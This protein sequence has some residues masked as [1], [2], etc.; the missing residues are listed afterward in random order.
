MKKNKLAKESSLYL[1]Q[2]ADNPVE[3]Y[4]W[5][6]EAFAK[7]VQE[8]KPVLLSIGY[9]ACHWCHVMANESFSD[10]E[11]AQLM[12]EL[13]VNIKVDKQER[14]DLDKIYLIAHQF[15]TGRGGGWPLTIFINPVDRMP[16]FAGTYFPKDPHHG[17]V[18]FKEVLRKIAAFYHNNQ[19]AIVKQNVQ[20]TSAFEQ[21]EIIHAS[22]MT[23]DVNLLSEAMQQFTHEYDAIYGGFGEAPK[24]PRPANLEFLLSYSARKNDKQ[25]PDVSLAIVNTSLTKMAQ[26]GLY[27]HL[28]GGF[29]RYCVDEQWHIPHFEKMLYDNG[30]LLMV[31]AMAD[32]IEPQPIFQHIL[33]QTGEWVLR[34]M[35][36]P[37]GGFYSTLDADSEHEEGKF[38]L[39]N[40]AEVQSLLTAE[41]YTL[42]AAYFGLEKPANFEGVWH[43]FE[44]KSLDEMAAALNSDSQK[45]DAL[46]LSACKKLFQAREQRIHPARDENILTSWNALMIKGLAL[47][48]FALNNVD[49]IQSAQRAID[50]VRTHRWKNK[51][52]N[53]GARGNNNAYLDDYAFLLDA[54]IT[55]LTIEWRSEDL[56]FAVEIADS[57]LSHFYDEANGGFYFTSHENESLISRLKP[58]QDEAIPA[59]NGIAAFALARLGNLL[60]EMRYK[61]ASENTLKMAALAIASYPAAYPSLLMALEDYF[62]PPEMV[63]IL[64]EMDAL[65]EWKKLS[66]QYYSPKR[67]V[68]FMAADEKNIPSVFAQRAPKKGEVVAYVCQGMSCFEPINHIDK[69]EEFLKKG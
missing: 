3:W 4:P 51:R 16:F 47:A 27:D 69:F 58:L 24:F 52:L 18:G 67:L 30:Q 68:F 21:L 9:S 38:Y 25:E 61:E 42:V 60:G 23:L 39:W 66:Q 11:T 65:L 5:G 32:S 12:N 29:F 49:F 37:E 53:S 54:L 22:A 44:N 19:D 57:L 14:P 8:K 35:Q 15:L 56:H 26:S 36:S 7:A 6:E 50:F 33:Q 62:Y 13:F 17:L 46:L 28:G 64:G 10:P 48:G 41:E 63:L 59:G 31:Y 2:H 1:Q 20:L 45:T 43:L 55:L 34:D 40:K